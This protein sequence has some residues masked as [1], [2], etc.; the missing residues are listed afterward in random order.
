MGSTENSSRT[1][2]PAEDL[3]C[4]QCGSSEVETHFET[5]HFPYGDGSDEVQLEARVPVRVCRACQFQY[6]DE[7]AEKI[8]H[9]TLCRY[10][11]VLTPGEIRGIREQYGLSRAEFARLTRLGEATLSRWENGILVQNQAYDQYLKL[12]RLPENFERLRLVNDS[13]SPLQLA[14]PRAG[15]IY[16]FRALSDIGRVRE[17]QSNFRLHKQAA[18]A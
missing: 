13:P 14:T 2:R 16:R 1:H 9:E 7:A 5:D 15:R 18:A 17:E 10:L 4:P 3:T 8:R 6:L 12:L 11:G